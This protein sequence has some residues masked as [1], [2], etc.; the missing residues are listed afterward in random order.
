MTTEVE[1]CPRGH[2]RLLSQYGDLFCLM[3]SYSPPLTADE[4]AQL[5]T[6]AVENV[7]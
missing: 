5:A 2:G 7:P 6:L 3:C 4:Q 1:H